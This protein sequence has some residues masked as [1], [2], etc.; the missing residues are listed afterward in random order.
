MSVV[1]SSVALPAEVSKDRFARGSATFAAVTGIP[2]EEYLDGF[3]DSSPDFGRYVI[4]WVFGDVYSRTDL[5][6]KTRELV[7]IAAGA[8]LGATGI[9][10]IKF[11]VPTAVRAG[12]TRDQIFGVLTQVAIV[13]GVPTA[14]APISA[15][16][17]VLGPHSQVADP[18]LFT[19]LLRDGLIRD[20][21]AG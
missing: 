17:Q 6:L 20:G 11:H 4:E 5:D 7:I 14:I 12:A 19:G 16:A 15:A 2:T 13:A 8:A 18:L 1:N 3:K 9:D 10:V 21:G